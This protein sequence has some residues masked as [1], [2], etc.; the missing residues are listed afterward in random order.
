MADLYGVLA[1]FKTAEALVDAAKQT[2]GE[3]YREID[4]FTPFPVEEL[5]DVLQLQHSHQVHW[6]GFF[7]ACFGAA[8]ALA[9][10]AFTNWDYPINVGGRPIYAWSAF[11]VVT[12]ELTVLFGALVPAFGMLALNGL[13]RLNYPVFGAKRFHLATR[14][15]FFLLI[16]AGDPR[17][18]AAVTPD[19]LQRLG[20][21]SIEMVA[22]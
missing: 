14:D 17:F 12:F 21:V 10:Q 11:A 8:L 18:D 2:R 6:L 15:R 13:P 22:R 16:K 5:T 7:G 20:P 3:G 4:A 9:M 19:F 1:E